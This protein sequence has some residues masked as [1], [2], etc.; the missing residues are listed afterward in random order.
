MLQIRSCTEKEKVEPLEKALVVMTR[1]CTRGQPTKETKGLGTASDKLAVYL[2]SLILMNFSHRV[3]SLILG[4]KSV[5][6]SVNMLRDRKL[7]LLPNFMNYRRV[8]LH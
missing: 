5:R 3:N 4:L 1:S 6:P 8:I 2:Q 7:S